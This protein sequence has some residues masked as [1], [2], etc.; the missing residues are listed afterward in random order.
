[1]RIVI[2]RRL[3]LAGWRWFF[4]IVAGKNHETLAQSES[5]HNF[6]DCEHTAELLRSGLASAKIEVR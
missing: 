4:R 3:T 1:M 5:Y 2:F 6:K